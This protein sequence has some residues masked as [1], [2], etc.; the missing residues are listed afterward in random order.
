[1]VTTSKIVRSTR[2]GQ[3]TIPVEFRRE[4]GFEGEGLWQVSVIDHGL[5]VVPVQVEQAVQG[6]PW[7][8]ELY[9]YFAPVRDEIRAQGMSEE[10]VNADIESAIRAVRAER[11]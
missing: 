8:K 10:D 5:R 3:I 6:S 9:D 4:L 11:G 7:L 2:N 1:M